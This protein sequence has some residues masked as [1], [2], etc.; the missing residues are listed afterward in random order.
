MTTNLDRTNQKNTGKT[1]E[2]E[3]DLLFR[4]LEIRKVARIRKVDPPVRVVGGGFARRTIFLPNP[5]LDYAGVFYSSGRAIFVEAKSTSA[6]R[7]PI[8]R[9]GGVTEE[10]V[11]SLRAWARAG[12]FVGVLWRYKAST[13]FISMKLLDACLDWGDKSLRFEDFRTLSRVEDF[14]L[15]P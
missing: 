15:P 7:L 4:S 6:H 14:L 5:F 8:G 3:L 1:F 13:V 12:A 2:H 11:E 9:S 10:Q